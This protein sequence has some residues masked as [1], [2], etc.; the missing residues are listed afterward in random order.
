MSTQNINA[1]QLIKKV[2]ALLLSSGIVSVIERI[3]LAVTQQRQSPI[4]ASLFGILNL[5][6]DGIK[7]FSKVSSEFSSVSS[8]VLFAGLLVF[9]A[10]LMDISFTVSS[11]L[12]LTVFLLFLVFWLAELFSLSEFFL[13]IVSRN[14]FVFLAL[15]R[16]AVI[17]VLLTLTLEVLVIIS[18]LTPIKVFLDSPT[19]SLTIVGSLTIFFVSIFVVF[20][21][22]GKVPFDVIEAESE[23]IDG[24]SVDIS[25]G[26]FSLFYAAEVIEFLA[27]LKFLSFS[28]LG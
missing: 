6:F 28:F 23:V 7:L 25:G 17:S 4:N 18:F 15:S 20:L 26:I 14:H 2:V 19:F 11:N 13:A 5:V 1:N 3:L 9:S 24:I 8:S 16:A 27:L 21:F 22:A 10:T 12:A